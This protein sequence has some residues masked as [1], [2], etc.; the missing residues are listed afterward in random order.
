MKSKNYGKSVSIYFWDRCQICLSG[1]G[2]AIVIV[3]FCLSTNVSYAFDTIKINPKNN[4]FSVENKSL[5]LITTKYISWTENW[6]WSNIKLN[7]EEKLDGKG[8]YAGSTFTGKLPKL[9]VDFTGQLSILKNELTW[10]YVWLKRTDRPNAKGIGIEFKF[11]K[12]S[13]FFAA[14]SNFPEILG[15]KKGWRWINAKGHKVEL[16]FNPPPSD[17]YYEKGKKNI[18][19]AFFFNGVQRGKSANKMQ[20]KIDNEV[21]IIAQE[22][23]NLSQSDLKNMIAEPLITFNSPIDLSFLNARDKPAGK[24][25]YLKATEDK[26]VFSDGS[27]AKF[28]G[29]N[30]MAYALFGTPESE[31]KAHARRISSLGFNLI[32]IHHHDSDWVKPNIF[33]NPLKNTHELS[34][35]ALRK[36]DF[37]IKCLKEEGV[38]IWMDLHVGRAFTKQDNVNNFEDIAKNKERRIVKGF[39]YINQSIQQQMQEFTEKYLNHINRYTGLAYKDDPSVI[40]FLITNEN[41]LTHHFNGFFANRKK[42]PEHYDLLVSDAKKFSKEQGWNEKKVTQF[43]LMGEPKMYLNDVEHRFNQKMIAHLKRIKTKSLLV[44][45]NSWGKMGL[46]SLPSL[47]DSEIIDVHSYAEANEF[48]YNPR[49]SPGFLSWIGAAQL[50]GKPLSVSEW[51]MGTFPISDRHNLPLYVA[52]IASLQGWD[53]MMLYGYSQSKLGSI[54]KAGN[55]SAY[56]DP[57]IMGLMPAAAL[58]FRQ[59]H[60]TEGELHYEFNLNKSDFFFKRQDPTTSKSLRTLLETSRFSVS[61]PQTKELPWLEK[62]SGNL[63]NTIIVQDANKDFI[64]DGQNFVLSDTGEL[65]RDWEKGIHVI[66]TSNSQAISGN[67]G[68][69]IINLKDVTFNIKTKNAV[70]VVQSFDG[71]EIKKSKAIFI[72]LMAKTLTGKDK[73][74][75]FVSEPVIGDITVQAQPG[76]KLYPVNQLG[77][78]EKPV[79]LTYSDG[80][81]HLSFDNQN[82]HHWFQ[83][84][85]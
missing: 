78:L 71:D 77:K 68:G 64:P 73:K 23:L 3:V 35:N 48:S 26:L 61:I 76:L 11:N 2:F 16:T 49:Y 18:I 59:K 37:W 74:L 51:N 30:V 85:L 82:Y 22:Q 56:N 33:Q 46:D 65:K 36:I 45:T 43:W 28:W 44:T 54:S 83:L 32:R 7:V 34:E 14:D 17:I 21:K 63:R 57:A 75:P 13:P 80:K 70:A 40:A 1:I 42:F 69:E 62:N 25:G 6:K 50:T 29:A 12:D 47:S 41:D 52:G 60:V 39:N 66:N 5:P 19:R 84:K 38:Y 67:I 72:T 8:S 9:D 53:A 81:Y 24:R 15:E 79:A 58:M 31:I 10:D 27:E 20:L 4:L 55:W